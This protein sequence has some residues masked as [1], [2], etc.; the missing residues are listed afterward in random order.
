MK[1]QIKIQ[2][3]SLAVAGVAIMALAVP[4]AY[5]QTTADSELTQE[6]N[7]GILSTSVRDG[8][9][10]I[11]A[12]P[13]F[14]MSAISASTS[15][16]TSTGTFGSSTQRIT[17]DNPGGASNGWTLALNATVPGTGNWTTGGGSPSTYAY[18]GVSAAAGQLTVNPQAGTITPVIGGA[19]GVTRGTQATFSGTSAITIMQASSSAAPIWNGY[20][21]GIGLSQTIPPAQAVGNYTIDMTQTVTAL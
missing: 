1:K 21:T 7:E 11:V 14:A 4:F 8:S 18:N 6:I 15:Q 20:I 9:G 5:A 17:V 10:N 16:Q 2:L 12:S 19:T 13:T 3:S